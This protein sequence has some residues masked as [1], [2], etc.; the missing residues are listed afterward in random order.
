[1]HV[2]TLTQ[3]VREAGSQWV[4]D[5]AP[6]LGAALAYYS[7]FSIA[8]LLVIAIAV[9]GL[10]FGREAAQGQISAQVEHLVGR[11]GGEA[12]EAMVESAS[13]PE[14]GALG[15]I[16]GVAM[17]LLGAGGLFGQLQDA[18]NTVWEVRPRPD[19]GIWGAFRDRF[20]S[21]SMVLGVAFLL[22]VSLIASSALAA[23]TTLLGHWQ[24]GTAGLV[25]TTALDLA[26]V[27]LLFALIYKYLPDAEIAWRDVWFGAA[28]TSALFTLG[29]FLIGLY[30][31]RAGV[32]SAYGAAGSLAVLLVWL[33]YASQIFLF[34][35]ELTKAFADHLGSRIKPKAHAEPVTAEAR[36]QEGLAPAR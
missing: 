14:S 4:T 16:L 9:A 7:I 12:V 21:L 18:L 29:K 3:I 27:T 24:T 13:K 22:L 35:A 30:L 8:P 31:G 19:R 32:G 2:G 26:T 28:I 20:L 33:Y 17:L 10:V 25:L 34:G 6:R 11:Q 15:S 23:A 36:A 5:K 1:M